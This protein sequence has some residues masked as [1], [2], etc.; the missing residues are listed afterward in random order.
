M[1]EGDFCPKC[2]KYYAASEERWRCKCPKEPVD[3]HYTDGRPCW[4]G[5]R[6]LKTDGG[7]DI[8]VHA[9]TH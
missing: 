7:G 4:C 3:D 5:P 8:I 2:R 9:R 1:S 6:T